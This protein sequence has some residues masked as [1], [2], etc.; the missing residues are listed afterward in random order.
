MQQYE[1]P[2]VPVVLTGLT[3]AWPAQQEWTVRRLLERFKE[4]RFKVCVHTPYVR[5]FM[6]LFV[7]CILQQLQHVLPFLPLHLA[8]HSFTTHS[9]ILLVSTPFTSSTHNP[10]TINT[11]RWALMMTATQCGCDSTTSYATAPPTRTTRQQTTP[12]CTYSTARMGSAAAATRWP[13]T[14]A[15]RTCFLK[16][17]SA[18]W[19]SAGG[20]RT[21]TRVWLSVVALVLFKVICGA[22][23]RIDVWMGLGVAGLVVGWTCLANSELQYPLYTQQHST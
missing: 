10:P 11:P 3:E 22:C 4:H 15:C 5:G 7:R 12:H 14:T 17:Y 2:R 9:T 19:G 8:P 16:T 23:V 13:G 18:L 6:W 21:G 20:H 1:T